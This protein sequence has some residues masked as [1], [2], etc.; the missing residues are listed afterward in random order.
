MSLSLLT[1]QMG[2]YYIEE[3]LGL[4][5]LVYP[6]DEMENK[7]NTPVYH[8]RSIWQVNRIEVKGENL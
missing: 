7:L 4:S 3:T 5:F 2:N 8:S 1:K 6:Y